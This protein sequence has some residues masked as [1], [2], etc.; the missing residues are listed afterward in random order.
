MKELKNPLPT[1]SAREKQWGLLYL[2][3]KEFFL[4]SLLY[5]FNDMLTTPLR[6]GLLNFL[7]FF[8][9]ATA[10][11]VIFGQFLQK[12]LLRASRFYRRILLCAGA[13]FAGYW[14][15]SSVLTLA[16]QAAFPD[17]VN[18]NDSTV[19]SMTGSD[20]AFMVLGTVL[21]AP[22]AEELLY[23]GLIFGGLHGKN[24]AAAYLI[25]ALLFAA[26]HVLSFV[27]R[28]PTGYALLA[29]VQYLPAG[30]IFAWSYARSGSV[31]T[32]LLIHIIN[33]AVVLITAR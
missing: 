6:A 21:L 25:S 24:A 32:P 26:I 33:N 3:F 14:V 23:R 13:G 17:Y 5:A 19:W 28:Y 18:L 8:I 31:F 9:N 4:S 15:C 2:L 27:G 11:V 12:N 29:L 22:I 20:P 16:I 10:T 1:L 7:Y 30:L